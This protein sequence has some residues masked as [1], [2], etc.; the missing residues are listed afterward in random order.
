MIGSQDESVEGNRNIICTS[1]DSRTIEGDHSEIDTPGVNKEV[2][3]PRSDTNSNLLSCTENI[4][5]FDTHVHSSATQERNL[6][7][8]CIEEVGVKSISPKLRKEFDSSVRVNLANSVLSES[9]KFISLRHPT[10]ETADIRNIDF[11]TSTRAKNLNRLWR[12]T[13]RYDRLGYTHGFETMSETTAYHNHI[14]NSEIE[15]RK[16]FER[17][18]SNE[19]IE[20]IVT[21]LD[22]TRL[23]NNQ[24]T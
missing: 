24:M 2:L 12:G 20:N 23:D 22:K 19:N 13:E 16:V 1:R 5:K 6:E 15:T 21:Q 9:S 10:V 17:E 4:K 14:K 18:T 3:S 11:T 7:L 8:L